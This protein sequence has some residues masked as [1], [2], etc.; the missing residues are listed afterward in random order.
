MAKRVNGWLAR[1]GRIY[2]SE[3]EAVFVDA[4]AGLM[5]ACEREN[6][7]PRKFLQAVTALHEEIQAYLRAFREVNASKRP[8]D[9]K[10]NARHAE[11][12]VEEASIDETRARPHT[13]TLDTA[14]D[15]GREDPT[16]GLLDEPTSGDEPV[17]D[18]WD[19]AQPPDVP[20]EQQGVALRSGLY[21]ARSVQRHATMAAAPLTGLT[22][23]R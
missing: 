1:D 16:A 3:V 9:G 12:E 5:E 19:S 11:R 18:L 15:G 13:A 23:T 7:A 14:D 4:T 21:H 2:A 6:I 20:K 17:S 22:G 8:G 10:S